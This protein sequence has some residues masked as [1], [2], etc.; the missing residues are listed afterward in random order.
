MAHTPLC[1]SVF[2]GYD[3]P[4]AQ[5][6]EAL[7]PLETA[8]GPTGWALLIDVYT[9][10]ADHFVPVLVVPQVAFSID[11]PCVADDATRTRLDLFDPRIPHPAA[12]DAYARLAQRSAALAQI[13]ENHAY[14]YGAM[15]RRFLRLA[16]LPL[17]AVAVMA[18][19]PDGHVLNAGYKAALG[20]GQP[21]TDPHLGALAVAWPDSAHQR[22]QAIERAKNA[23]RM[24]A[25]LSP[26]LHHHAAEGIAWDPAR[27]VLP[28]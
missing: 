2:D 22:L 21:I 17:D 10:E 15:E 27:L 11:H 3:D 4:I 5:L 12:A 24:M 14:T 1:P 6:R 23:A 9:V 19:D 20:T 25:D 7:A 18:E 26:A 16:L 28:A 8:L 13:C